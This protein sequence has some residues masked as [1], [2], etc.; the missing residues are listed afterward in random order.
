[1]KDFEWFV[2][3]IGSTLIATGRELAPK[4]IHL[5]TYKDAILH[6]TLNVHSF[7]YNE[8]DNGTSEANYDFPEVADTTP[9]SARRVHISDDR[10]VAC[11]G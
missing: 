3:R 6:H 1:M 4:E 8:K 10:C 2:D 11:E 7:M 9:M 5:R